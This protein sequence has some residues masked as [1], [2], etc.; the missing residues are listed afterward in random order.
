MKLIETK[1]GSYTVFNESIKEPYHSVS[2][3]LEEAFEKHVKPLQIKSGMKLLDF[4]FGIGYNSIAALYDHKDLEITALEIDLKIVQLMSEIKVPVKIKNI[5]QTYSA[6]ALKRKI[7]DNNNN[8]IE[9]ILGDASE[10]IKVLPSDY[11]DRIFFDPFSPQKQPELWSLEIFQE[12]YRILKKD[13]RLSTYSCAGWIRR[14]F[15]QAGFAVQDGPIIGRRSPSTI[16][17]KK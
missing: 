17:Q 13:G 6:L 10:T 5:Y 15:R 3:A 1:D 14:N 4:C 2:G 16:A 12:L 11:F 8:S 9:L 7:K